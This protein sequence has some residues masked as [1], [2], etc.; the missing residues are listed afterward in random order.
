MLWMFVAQGFQFVAPLPI[1]EPA[2]SVRLFSST[3]WVGGS[4]FLHSMDVNF[5]A[6]PNPLDSIPAGQGV[7]LAFSGADVLVMA[8]PDSGMQV[9]YVWNPS[10]IQAAY[11]TGGS[12]RSVDARGTTAYLGTPTSLEVY[13]VTNPY[14]PSWMGSWNGGIEDFRVWGDFAYAVDGSDTFRILNVLNP[15]SI[16][17]VGTVTLGAVG[18]A[19]DLDSVNLWVFVGTAA[20][21]EVWDVN[22]PTSPVRVGQCATPAPVVR[23]RFRPPQYV[24]LIEENQGIRALDILDPSQCAVVGFLAGTFFDVD[25]SSFSLGS[26]YVYAVGTASG[27]WQFT[28]T[29]VVETSPRSSGTFFTVRPGQ[30]ILRTPAWLVD[31]LG[32]SSW[33]PPGTH[34]LSGKYILVPSISRTHTRVV[35]P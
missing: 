12:A 19:V 6:S 16:V 14:L 23:V 9:Y 27:V 28:P 25:A 32:R 15:S 10:Q 24:F 35:I 17:E 5:P 29:G 8:S 2:Y 30:L 34:R 33:L 4:A 11:T 22:T 18:H 1:G 21:L 20:G 3:L 7:D 13:D 26:A 31:P